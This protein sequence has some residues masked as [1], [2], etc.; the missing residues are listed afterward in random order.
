MI[1]NVASRLRSF[2]TGRDLSAES[3]VLSATSC[4][5]V[6]TP[7]DILDFRLLQSGGYANQ[8]A[9]KHRVN[10]N[11]FDP[12]MFGRFMVELFCGSIW[13]NLLR[14]R[15]MLA[16]PAFIIRMIF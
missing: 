2:S 5:A 6:F 8:A 9:G 1:S 7:F 3:E 14:S 15:R 4:G 10:Q 13:F 12:F 11:S 16:L